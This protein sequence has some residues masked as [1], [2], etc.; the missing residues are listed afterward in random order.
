MGVWLVEEGGM[1]VPEAEESLVGKTSSSMSS[2]GAEGG[3][4]PRG[5]V[6][7]LRNLTR[8]PIG[9]SKVVGAAGGKQVQ[10]SSR[11]HK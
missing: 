1:W 7:Q 3:R 5:S 2:A 4:L 6:V 11:G 8:C 9:V 10:G